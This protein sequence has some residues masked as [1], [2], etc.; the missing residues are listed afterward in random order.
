MRDQMYKIIASRIR[1]LRKIKRYS[2]ERLEKEC[3]LPSQSIK[4]TEMEDVSKIDVYDMWAIADNFNVDLDYLIGKQTEERRSIA[5][6]SKVTGLSYEAVDI[7]SAFGKMNQ[8]EID[9][10]SAMICAPSFLPFI[11][12]VKRYCLLEDDSRH[13]IKEGYSNLSDK[14][15]MVAA[16]QSNVSML[17]NEAKSKAHADLMLTETRTRAFA[18]IASS[19]VKI[20]KEVSE[21]EILESL[22]ACGLDAEKERQ[23]FE[24]YLLEYKDYCKRRAQ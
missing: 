15:I 6:V 18:L 7:L 9:T 22:S 24:E 11:D 21:T 14:E 8:T 10:L 19:I 5:D 23:A 20:D 4:R 1:Q 3:R 17:M 13:M 2:R 16:I 12:L